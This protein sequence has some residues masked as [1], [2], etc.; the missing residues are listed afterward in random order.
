VSLIAKRA[1]RDLV[2]SRGKSKEEAEDLV[3]R[4]SGH[5]LRAGYA[6]SA[7]AADVSAL[8][9]QQHTTQER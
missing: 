5:S 6:A 2:R 1:M 9:I 7:A 3:R 4:F 8:R